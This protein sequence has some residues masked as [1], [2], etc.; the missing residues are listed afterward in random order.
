MKNV[1]MGT[2]D[3]FYTKLQEFV[4]V[5]RIEGKD[6]AVEDRARWMGGGGI[7]SISLDGRDGFS[8]RASESDYKDKVS[9]VLGTKNWNREDYVNALFARLVDYMQKPI[10]IKVERGPRRYNHT[11]KR[12]IVEG[13]LAVHATV[14]QEAYAEHW[15]ISDR[16]LRRLI[17]EYKKGNL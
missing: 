1:F 7:F 9:F 8:I 12:Q 10:K 14:T 2:T 5:L 6:I 11:E 16:Q 4:A 13:Y 15:H 17:T 3:E